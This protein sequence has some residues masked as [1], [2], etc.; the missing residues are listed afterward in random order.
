MSLDTVIH[1][2]N[3]ESPAS[4]GLL[5]LFRNKLSGLIAHFSSVFC[6]H[7]MEKVAVTGGTVQNV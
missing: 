3:S 5:L 4:D 6:G 7:L 2:P 1:L